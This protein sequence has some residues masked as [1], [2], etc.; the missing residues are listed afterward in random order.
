MISV[1]TWISYSCHARIV[2]YLRILICH[3][4]EVCLGGIFMY[5][6][7]QYPK[8]YTQLGIYLHTDIA[9]PDGI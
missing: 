2:K 8:R 6:V 1:Y 7:T 4:Q 5:T 9:Y 3:M